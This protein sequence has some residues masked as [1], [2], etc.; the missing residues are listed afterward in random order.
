MLR[1]RV[2]QADALDSVLTSLSGSE[3][4]GEQLCGPYGNQRDLE[5]SLGTDKGY[6]GQF[7]DSVTGLDY[8]NARWYD[9]VSGQFVSP[10]SVQG[11][12]QGMDPYAYVEGNP[13]TRTDPTGHWGWFAV[14][15]AITVAALAVVTVATCGVD[16]PILLAAG[17]GA[18]AAG[19]IAGLV[20]GGV[21]TVA[22]AAQGDTSESLSDAM[23]T[24]GEDMIVGEIG[25]ALAFGASLI[26]F[27]ALGAATTLTGNAASAGLSYMLSGIIG[28]TATNALVAGVNW[29]FGRTVP[30]AHAATVSLDAD[31]SYRHTITQKEAVRNERKAIA[32]G[33]SHHWW[34]YRTEAAF[35]RAAY[36]VATH[37]ATYTPPPG[38]I[39]SHGGGGLHM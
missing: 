6:T 27:G 33:N 9:P 17:A 36:S 35:N 26:P 32:Y 15:M 5:G 30:T 4:Q 22:Q 37:I 7:A 13:E 1:S 38:W 16:V 31:T 3:I 2:S 25:G 28:G 39:P 8:Y 29:F 21:T 34:G 20:W 14:G 24:V 23:D 12:A 10:D 18:V 19:G 11:N